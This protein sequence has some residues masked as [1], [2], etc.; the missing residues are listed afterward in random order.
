MYCKYTGGNVEAEHS[1]IKIMNVCP[2]SCWAHNGLP[3]QGFNLNWH[4]HYHFK[5]HSMYKLISKCMKM[6]TDKFDIFNFSRHLAT[7]HHSALFMWRVYP[8]SKHRD[9]VNIYL[10]FNIHLFHVQVFNLTASDCSLQR[11]FMFKMWQMHI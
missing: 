1:N 5:S 10:A 9:G 7:L 3:G 6:W 8:L 4:R 2:R 11:T